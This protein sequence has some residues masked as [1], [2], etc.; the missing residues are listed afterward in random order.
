M[1]KEQL[2]PYV[3]IKVIYQTS[4]DRGTCAQ[5][6]GKVFENHIFN[7]LCSLLHTLEVFLSVSYLHFVLYIDQYIFSR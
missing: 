1:W 5:I 3:T 4:C 7:K 6:L 2:A